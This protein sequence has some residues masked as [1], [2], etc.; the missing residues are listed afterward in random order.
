VIPPSCESPGG[1][2]VFDRPLH[3]AGV[4]DN[5][6]DE[7][8]RTWLGYDWNDRTRCNCGMVARQIMQTDAL[9]LKKLLPPIVEDGVFRPTWSAMTQAHCPDSG[10][11]QNEVFAR[12]LSAGLCPGDFSHLEELSD[13][14]I[15]GRAEPLRKRKSPVCRSRKTDVVAYLRAWAMG[16]EEFHDRKPVASPLPSAATASQ[17]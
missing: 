8:A 6:A 17:S 7:L 16:I 5:T 10:L 4:L 12:L 2:Q 15:L 13:P 11:P 3:L 9:K 1:A 14:D